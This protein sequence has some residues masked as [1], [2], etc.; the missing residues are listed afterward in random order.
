MEI[1][2][3][4]K[5][6]LIC[7]EDIV[8]RWT[9]THGIAQCNKCGAPYRIY[10]YEND[11]RVDREPELQLRADFIEPCRE[12]WQQKRRPMPGGFSFAADYEV[13]SEED[14]EEWYAWMDSHKPQLVE[15]ASLR[16]GGK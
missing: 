16:E 10:H 8:V 6:C 14:R 4:S 13:S 2:K 11:K 7:K 1:P 3:D 9:D 15:A 5:Q 12:Y